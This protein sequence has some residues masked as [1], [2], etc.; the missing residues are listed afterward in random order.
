MGKKKQELEIIYEDED[1][2]ALNKPPGMPTVSDEF[3][4]PGVCDVL[5]PRVGKLYVIY[6]LEFDASGVVCLAKSEKAYEALFEKFIEQDVL[7]I[8]LA[9]ISG[10]LRKTE[11]RI[12]LPIAESSEPVRIDYERGKRAITEYKVIEEYR[13]YSLVEAKVLTFRKHQVR[14]HFKAIGHPLAI[15]PIYGDNSS[16]FLSDI[17]RRK[18][19]PKEGQV[20]RPLISRLTLHLLKIGFTH[21]KNGRY[22][23]LEARLPKDLSSLVKQLRKYS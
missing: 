18:Y 20:E 16:I 5:K 1:Y 12:D 3:S 7:I 23:E 6:E 13:D 11:G 22:I 10:H 17:K 9:V 4:G 14:V 21:F 15:D 19:L 2:I 8:Y